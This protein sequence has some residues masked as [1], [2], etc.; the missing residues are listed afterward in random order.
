MEY[1][2]QLAADGLNYVRSIPV[3]VYSWIVYSMMS[4]LTGPQL[5][6]KNPLLAHVRA[7]FPLILPKR[8][9]KTLP[10]MEISP[11]TFPFFKATSIGPTS[12][13]SSRMFFNFHPTN[14]EISSEVLIFLIFHWFIQ[15]FQISFHIWM[16][17]RARVKVECSSM[18]LLK[19]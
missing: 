16:C 10:E 7:H 17:T 15:N 6:L 13:N 3:S 2:T 5:E 9:V 1:F 4:T 11:E 18:R 8:W 12:S 14:L 19:N